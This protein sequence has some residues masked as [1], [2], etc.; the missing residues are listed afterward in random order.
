MQHLELCQPLAAV[1]VQL[2][3]VVRD[4]QIVQPPM[5]IV[6]RSIRAV[7][8]AAHV[9]TAAHV[10]AAVVLANVL[11]DLIRVA[12]DRVGQIQRC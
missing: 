1:P 10:L 2:V 4:V 3:R 8:A 5:L 7:E 9:P 11:V 6:A 12:A